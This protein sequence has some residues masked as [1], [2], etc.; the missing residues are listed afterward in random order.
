MTPRLT[1]GLCALQWRPSWTGLW[2][3]HC[4]AWYG[5]RVRYIGGTSIHVRLY[6]SDGIHGLIEM[7][8]GL[9]PRAA[10]TIGFTCLLLRLRES[11]S[12]MLQ[13]RICL[14]YGMTRAENIRLANRYWLASI[15][16]FRWLSNW[17][18]HPRAN[19]PESPGLQ[20]SALA[21]NFTLLGGGFLGRT[22]QYSRQQRTAKD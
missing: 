15:R 9:Q 3:Y 13:V 16:C 4:L 7:I 12:A 22:G 8:E 18:N 21:W 11:S 2:L 6:I 5:S 14:N 20:L 17:H 19:C 10:N 1:I